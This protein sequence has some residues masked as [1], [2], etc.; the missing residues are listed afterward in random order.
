MSLV[1]PIPLDRL[2]QLALV[3]RLRQP[4]RCAGQS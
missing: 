3:S 1:I 2:C 4:K